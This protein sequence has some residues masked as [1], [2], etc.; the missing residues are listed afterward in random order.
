MKEGMKKL[1]TVYRT[2][3][4]V[5]VVHQDKEMTETVLK[6]YASQIK[7]IHEHCNKDKE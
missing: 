2:E 7:H 6:V 5:F 1:Q 3:N 4:L